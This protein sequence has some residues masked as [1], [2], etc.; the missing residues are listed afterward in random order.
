MDSC[1][2]AAEAGGC[3]S[4]I[5]SAPTRLSAIWLTHRK[6]THCTDGE[7]QDAA[8]LEK[9]ERHPAKKEKAPL[10]APRFQKPKAWAT[11]TLLA[12]QVVPPA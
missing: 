2:A 5:T 3:V 10:E 7:S 11:P 8:T 1:A 6:L 4:R 9:H 12:S